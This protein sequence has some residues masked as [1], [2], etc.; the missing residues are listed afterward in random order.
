VEKL[1]AVN[2]RTNLIYIESGTF[3]ELKFPGDGLVIEEYEDGVPT[4]G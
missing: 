3:K 4:R 1:I 2:D